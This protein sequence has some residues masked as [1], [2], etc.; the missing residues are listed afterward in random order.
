MKSVHVE[1][2]D[3]TVDAYD[4]LSYGYDEHGE[5]R[6][7]TCDDDGVANGI[8]LYP[9]MSTRRVT[10]WLDADDAADAEPDEDDA[11]HT[12]AIPTATFQVGG[13]TVRVTQTHDGIVLDDETHNW[14][15]LQLDP[16]GVHLYADVGED[17]GFELEAHD[18]VRGY[19]KTRW[20]L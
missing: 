20:D 10:E 14:Y 15:L 7:E 18:G 4:V 12:A 2:Q 1:L 16:D 5:L 11:I 9:D 3:G 8:V 19:L 13:T 6:L 17:A